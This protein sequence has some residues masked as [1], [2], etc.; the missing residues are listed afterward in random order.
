MSIATKFRGLTRASLT[1]TALILTLLLVAGG[2]SKRSNVGE[3]GGGD[4]GGGGGGGGTPVV[5]DAELPATAMIDFCDTD[6]LTDVPESGFLR[7]DIEAGDIV[8]LCSGWVF[9]AD[10]TNNRVV[11]RNIITGAIDSTYPLAGAPEDLEL[12]LVTKLLYA[13]LPEHHL[14][15]SINLITLATRYRDVNSEPGGSRSR[16]AKSWFPRTAERNFA[17]ITS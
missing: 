3:G 6:V 12:D 1:F 4:D 14:I 5:G 9:I 2:C 10:K 13:T 17:C 16:T 15:V 8:P 7:L 11:L